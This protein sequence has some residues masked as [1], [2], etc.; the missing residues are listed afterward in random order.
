MRGGGGG[1]AFKKGHAK[2]GGRRKG[3][4]NKVPKGLK[5]ATG[6]PVMRGDGGG[7]EF[8]RGHEKLGGRRKGTPNKLTVELYRHW[9]LAAEALGAD[10]LGKDGLVGHFMR[11][12]R[13][14]PELFCALLVKVFLRRP[15]AT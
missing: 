9:L 4:P 1:P 3:T 14:N 6:P 5:I 15:T 8:E 7:P 2:V 11:L 13:R 10:G 12:A